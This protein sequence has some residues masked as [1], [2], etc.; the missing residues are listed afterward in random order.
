M[1]GEARG[2]SE[3]GQEEERTRQLPMTEGSQPRQRNSRQR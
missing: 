2:E 1:E 3:A